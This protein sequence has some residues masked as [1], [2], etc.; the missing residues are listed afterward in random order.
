MLRERPRTRI[1]SWTLG[2]V[3][4]LLL[5][6]NAPA[7]DHVFTA[8]DST[9]PVGST[10]TTIITYDNTSSDSVAGWSMGVCHDP[11]MVDVTDAAFGSTTLV[12]GP[13]GGLPDFTQINLYPN[14]TEPT[15]F[16]PGANAAV[17][18]SFLGAAPLAP[19]FGYELLEVVHLLEQPGTS[20]V[21]LCETILGG[22][23]PVTNVVSLS[24]GQS[25]TPG[26]QSGTITATGTAAPDYLLYFSS[27][28]AL[29]GGQYG[30]TALADINAMDI[31]GWSFGICH[32]EAVLNPVDATMGATTATI[33]GGTPPDFIQINV[34]ENG[35]QPVGTTPGFNMAVVIDFLGGPT[36]P[37]GTGHELLDIVY[38][39]SGAGSTTISY[40]DTTPGGSTPVATVLSLES[41]ASVNPDLEDG[42]IVLTTTA[43]TF[44]RGDCDA[45]GVVDLADA[46][47]YLDWL[48]TGG[49]TPV[50]FDACDVN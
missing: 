29:V 2:G 15:G 3:L 47:S 26:T 23:T 4:A 17:V 5:A 7:Q 37:P 22:S 18:F 8:G 20:S 42:T 1:T 50:C 35:T 12:G 39:G 28:S 19:G 9:G 49:A 21:D 41:G 36:L 14:G 6:S 43:I 27:S 44:S 40:C 32:D 13:G 38:Q 16:S 34:I 31:A 45:S 25:V 33:Q 10:Q 30:A 48:F 24:T 11:S 46:M